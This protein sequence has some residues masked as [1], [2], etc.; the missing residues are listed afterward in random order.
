LADVEGPVQSEFQDG[1]DSELR[2]GWKTLIQST[3]LDYQSGPIA[4]PG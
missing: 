4:Q 1:A 2:Q 3:V